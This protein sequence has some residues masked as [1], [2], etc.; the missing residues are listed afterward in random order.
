M[1]RIIAAVVRLNVVFIL[2]YLFSLI[3]CGKAPLNFVLIKKTAFKLLSRIAKQLAIVLDESLNAVYNN[4]QSLQ[5]YLIVWSSADNTPLCR[6]K[7][8]SP[9]AQTDRAE[10]G[11]T[12]A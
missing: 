12:P 1:R 7:I 9:V 6:G 5:R 11:R 2:F 8:F 4:Y 3:I 10:G